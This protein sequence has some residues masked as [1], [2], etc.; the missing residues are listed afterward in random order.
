MRRKWAYY[1]HHHIALLF[2]ILP[3]LLTVLGINLYSPPWPARHCVVWPCLALPLPL[4]RCTPPSLCPTGLLIIARTGQVPSY[5]L[6]VS[7][8]PVFAPWHTHARC[9]AQLDRLHSDLSLNVRTLE[10]AWP[11][12]FPPS[13]TASTAV[14]L[15]VATTGHGFVMHSFSHIWSSP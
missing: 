8:L 2:K 5:Y 10:R 15:I 1:F 4:I 6:Q 14:L 13:D 7:I 9:F 12:T 3:W 11:T